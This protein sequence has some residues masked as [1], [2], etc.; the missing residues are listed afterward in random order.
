MDEHQNCFGRNRIITFAVIT[1]FKEIT[2]IIELI[3][4]IKSLKMMSALFVFMLTYRKHLV[5]TDI[6]EVRVT[7]NKTYKLYLVDKICK[8]N[9][10]QC[11]Q[12][13][14]TV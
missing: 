8:K 7:W 5:W 1:K 2:E 9:R 11:V 3:E 13:N 14:N 10:Q 6:K 12:S 4:L